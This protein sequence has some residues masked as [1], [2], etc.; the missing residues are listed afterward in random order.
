MDPSSLNKLQEAYHI[1]GIENS[2]LRD[3]IEALKN[4]LKK[5]KFFKPN[6]TKNNQPIKSCKRFK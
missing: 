3:E 2:N 4:Q 1:L 6:L 5:Q